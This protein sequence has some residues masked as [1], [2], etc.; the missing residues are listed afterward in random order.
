MDSSG[1]GW[2]VGDRGGVLHTDDFGSTWAI[3]DPP[4]DDA[5]FRDVL[6]LPGSGGAAVLISGPEL[7]LTTDNGQN[8]APKSFDNIYDFGTLQALDAQTIV[9]FAKKGMARSQDG[10]NNWEELLYPANVG[11]GAPPRGFFVSESEGW[12]AEFAVDGDLFHTTDG[13][14]TWTQVGTQTFLFPRGIHF[15]DDQHGLIADNNHVYETTDGGV[16]WTP[17]N[18]APFP[19]PRALWV[20]DDGFWVVP[21]DNGSIHYTEDGG[22]TWTEVYPVAYSPSFGAVASL[23]TTDFWIVGSYSTIL[24]TD[25]FVQFTEQTPGIKATIASVDFL[26]DQRG[27][28][29]STE[30][31]VL[32][33]LDGGAIWENITPDDFITGQK[34]LGQIYIESEDAVW[35]STFKGQMYFSGDFGESWQT[36]GSVGGSIS[37]FRFHK[38]GAQEF[39]AITWNG[40]FYHST[41]G[42]ASWTLME[43][44]DG[45]FEDIFFHNPQDG[46]LAGRDGQLLHTTDG[47]QNWETV[48]PGNDPLEDFGLIRFV[49]AQTGWAAPRLGTHIYRTEDGGQSWVSVDL[50]VGAFWKDLDFSDAQHLW[51]CGGSSGSGRVIQS[52]D[53]GAQWATTLLNAPQILLSL[54]CPVADEVAWVAGGAG[55]IAKWVVCSGETPVF[56]S[57]DGPSAPCLGDTV[58]YTADATAVDVFEWDF[59][60]AWFLLG[61]ENTAQVSVIVGE[62]QGDLIVTGQNTCG[63]ITQITFPLNFSLVPPAPPI[64]FVNGVLETPVQDV[65]AYHWYLDGVLTATTTTNTYAPTASGNWSL[66]VLSAEGCASEWSEEVFVTVTGTLGKEVTRPRLSPNPTDGIITIENLPARAAS[67]S[68]GWIHL[69]DSYGRSVLRTPIDRTETLNLALPENLPAGLYFLKIRIDD[70]QYAWKVL[71]VNH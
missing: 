44:L 47:G 32:R 52:V 24:R 37:D 65:A 39:V 28:A 64:D 67:S 5:H 25:D 66:R 9:A 36:L 50:P 22:S 69:T 7:Y 40:K 19:S 17:A 13:G 62:Q 10:G 70:R 63:D 30:G 27:L 6:I 59:P 49:D 18:A 2:A 21:D 42:A 16:Q 56:H 12:L 14:L 68:T 20:S 55:Q 35:L 58:Q 38:A 60:G 61:N 23:G 46:W 43:D 33:T 71:L 45:T 31:H 48:Q 3:L 26:D 51:L 4:V 15:F 57:I 1:T 29:V 54:S 11:I 34:N 41:D 53:G 8:W